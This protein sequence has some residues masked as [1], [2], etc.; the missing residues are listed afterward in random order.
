VHEDAAAAAGKPA[1]KAKR[2]ARRAEEQY[3]AECPM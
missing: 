3:G 2:K 1:E